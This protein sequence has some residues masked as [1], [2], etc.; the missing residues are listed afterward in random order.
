MTERRVS[1]APRSDGPRLSARPHPGRVV[2]C[3][4]SSSL[5]ASLADLVL[6]TLAWARRACVPLSGRLGVACAPRH[7]HTP[8]HHGTRCRHLD[9]IHRE[10]EGSISTISMR[11]RGAH[12]G[13]LA[14]AR[15]LTN[16][17]LLRASHATALARRASGVLS[18]LLS[19]FRRRRLVAS[20]RPADSLDLD[21]RAHV[22]SPVDA[23]AASRRSCL[24]LGLVLICAIYW[25]FGVV[26]PGGGAYS[27][28][29]SA[30]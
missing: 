15:P 24:T 17:T 30:A 6:P 20:C 16:P 14:A 9:G 1:V 12:F 19:L 2:P 28:R 7:A 29:T 21:R 8:V 26:Q 11:R 18:R 4:H 3:A 22:L 13:W 25:A 10:E 27:W 23:K 5:S